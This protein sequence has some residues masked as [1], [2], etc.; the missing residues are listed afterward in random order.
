MTPLVECLKNTTE[1]EEE[2]RVL[3]MEIL[4]RRGADPLVL[5]SAGLTAMDIARGMKFQDAVELLRGWIAGTVQDEGELT[6]I[7]STLRS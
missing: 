4:L 6:A 7:S 2:L 5:D 1:E 3:F